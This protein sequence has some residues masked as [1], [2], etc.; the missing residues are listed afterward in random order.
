MND[1]RGASQELERAR[2]EAHGDAP[3]SRKAE[4]SRAVHPPNPDR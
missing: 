3:D 4:V 2:A 1:T